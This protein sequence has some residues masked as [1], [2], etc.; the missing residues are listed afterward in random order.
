[1]KDPFTCSSFLEFDYQ[2]ITLRMKVN[3]CGTTH[4]D[5]EFS[6]IDLDIDNVL[7]TT[8]YI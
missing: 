6:R 4:A 1:M 7:L 2:F 3:V 5:C 8:H